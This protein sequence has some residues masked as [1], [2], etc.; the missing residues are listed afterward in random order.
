MPHPDPS[1]PYNLWTRRAWIGGMGLAALAGA[2]LAWHLRPDRFRQGFTVHLL[3]PDSPEGPQRYQ[4]GLQWCLQVHLSTLAPACVIPVRNPEARLPQGRSAF[5][6][7]LRPSRHGDRLALGFRW[8]RSG[9]PWVT[10]EGSPELPRISLAALLQALPEPVAPDREAR[11]L[12]RDPDSAWT[13]FETAPSSSGGL[14]NTARSRLERLLADEPRCAAAWCVL[15]AAGFQDLLNTS[16]WIPADRERTE[17]HFRRALAI[18]PGL[19]QAAGDLSQFLSDLGD[20]TGAL[21]ELASAIRIRPHAE[22]LLRRLAYSAR[23]AGLLP[24]AQRAVLE[25]EAR[26]GHLS[27][28][29]NTLLYLG[30]LDR[31]EAGIRAQGEEVGW[32]PSHRFYLGYAALIRGNAL[33]SS[34]RLYGTEGTWG[35][36]RFGRLGFVLWAY[37]EGRIPES[38]DTLEGLVR[39]HLAL[40]APDGEFIIK[41]AE[42]MQLLG[43]SSRALDLVFQA[44]S[45]GFTCVQWYE[46]SPFLAPIR[47]LPRFQALLFTL[48]ERQAQNARRFPPGHFSL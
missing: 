46:Q 26:T 24:L 8:R 7:Q 40:R 4:V 1:A 38:R 48:R 10:Q 29:E 23:N 14:T 35:G 42:L 22:L 45:S 18:V 20:H 27:G 5:Q 34:R 36:T 9:T 44:A 37:L 30:E 21:E 39:E 13:L 47:P 11:L 31:F 19:P 6:L 41:L 15:G 33:E 12:P 3:P 28:I 2:G 43:D 32:H 17:A 16:T 25:L